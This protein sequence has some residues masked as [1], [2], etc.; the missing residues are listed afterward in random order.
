MLQK[1]FITVLEMSLVASL[2]IPV[3]LLIRILLKK[4]PKVIS[5]GLWVVVLF[6]LLCPFSVTAVFSLIPDDVSSGE[7]VERVTDDYVGEIAV[8]DD[9]TEEYYTAV[10]AG[11]QPISSGSSYYVV[12][13]PDGI[14]EP[15]TVENTW[16]PVLSAVWLAGITVLAGYSI[17]SFL[18]LKQK[19]TGTIRLRDNIYLADSVS[20]PFVL[21]LFR[22]KI[23]LP[24]SLTEQEQS[25]IILHERH[26]IHRGDHI[27][28]VLAFLALC[29]HWFNPLVWLAFVL[30]GKDMEMS[31]DEA[32]IRRMGED[33]RGDYAASLLS[34]ATGWRFISG[35]PLAFGEG[36]VKD[37]IYNLAHRRKPAL[38]FTVAAV[39]ICLV[40]AVCLMT[41]PDGES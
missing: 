13:G 3:V 14:S 33:I 29:I 5:Y 10:E 22:P 35:T 41:D 6:R 38:V 32:V 27:V 1:I 11:R 4:L 23:Y 36:E 9:R 34:L 19:L 2:V 30:S 26:H 24:S 21:G 8:Y 7:L 20:C 40:M 18:T 37:R 15:A 39:V 17:G 16:I 28:K 25:Y 31:C 12:T